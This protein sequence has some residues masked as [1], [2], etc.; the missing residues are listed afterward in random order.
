L[1]A[2][3]LVLVDVVGFG[4]LV[5]ALAGVDEIGPPEQAVRAIV[6]ERIAINGIDVFTQH[7][8]R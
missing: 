3:V 1:P 4:W 8:L 6:V 7:S 2:A 5:L